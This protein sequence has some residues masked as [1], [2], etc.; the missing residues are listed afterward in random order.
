MVDMLIDVVDMTIDGS[1]RCRGANSDQLLATL[2]C[3]AAWLLRDLP[4]S[5]FATFAVLCV[6]DQGPRPAGA[7]CA[8]LQPVAARVADTDGPINVPLLHR[9]VDEGL[10]EIWHEGPPPGRKGRMYALTAHGA[11]A[12]A[13]LRERLREA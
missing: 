12:L 1:P 5:S 13:E 7:I 2:L 9:L 4:A 11:R 6:L 10:L 3:Q 8:A